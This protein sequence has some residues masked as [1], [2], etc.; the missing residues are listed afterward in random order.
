MNIIF[1]I[2]GGLGK[3]IMATAVLKAIRTQY[4]KDY[5]I[6]VT[7]F[8]DVFIN[9]PNANKILNHSQLAGIHSK[10]ILNKEAKVFISEPYM[11]S[12][13]ITESKHLIEIWCDLFGVAYNGETPELFI[14]DSERQYFEQFYRV[15][16]PIMVIQP[17]GGAEGQPLNYS[18]TRDIPQP[19]MQEVI[20]HFKHEYAIL[21]VKRQDQ[22]SY[23]NT[24]QALDD[25]RSIAILVSMSKKRL[26]ID[27]SVMHIAAALNLPSVV[28]W[29]GTNP[30]VFGYEMNTNVLA[31][32]PTVEHNVEHP[33]YTKHMLYEDIAKIP[34][35]NLNEIFDAKQLI[36]LLS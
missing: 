32:T 33:F 29:V 34:Y 28:T 19:V 30:K 13:Y 36:N 26:L 21:H 35:K 1:Q 2:D 8:P 22:L 31:N 3:S 9:N 15:D 7:G 4:P 10:Y 20:N 16:K 23:E 25:F 11:T 17:N 27:S 5:I 6:V 18:W 14:S 12:D 24:M